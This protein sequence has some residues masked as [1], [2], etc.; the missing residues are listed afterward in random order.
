MSD[1]NTT[2]AAGL[3][4]STVRQRQREID[5]DLMP[6]LK[7]RAMDRITRLEW[8]ALLK[9]VE[10]RAPEV[11]RNLRNHLWCM[12]EYAIDS[13][14]LENNPVPPLLVMKKRNQTNHPALAGDKIGDFL[15]AL[16]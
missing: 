11:A 5:T 3:R 2:T 14:L 10:K 6:K 4:P 12:F 15:H 8:T 7:A 13:G 9:D 1:W 16:D